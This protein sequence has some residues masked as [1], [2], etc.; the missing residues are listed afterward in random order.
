MKAAHFAW[1]AAFLASLAQAGGSFTPVTIESLKITGT[2]YTIV[3]VPAA[4]NGDD[5]MGACTRFTVHG[6]Y[7]YLDGAFLNQPKELSREQ[8][9]AALAYLQDA[10]EKHRVVNF[11]GMG[12]GF[13]PIDAAQPCVVKSA[14]YCSKMRRQQGALSCHFTMRF[15]I[16]ASRLREIV[17]RIDQLHAALLAQALLQQVDVTLPVEHDDAIAGLHLLQQARADR[18]I[19]VV[20]G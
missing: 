19:A 16:A 9:L 1:L 3:V 15:E 14:L 7:W 8:H 11:G 6:L 2:T 4:G 13:E 17:Q 10:F 12:S 20:P 18:E 5:Y